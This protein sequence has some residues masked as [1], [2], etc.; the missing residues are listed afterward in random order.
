MEKI[1]GTDTDILGAASSDGAL[2]PTKDEGPQPKTPGWKNRRPASRFIRVI[3][4][5]VCRN[6]EPEGPK[7]A[8]KPDMPDRMPNLVEHAIELWRL[9]Q[10]LGRLAAS[11]DEPQ[12]D[13]VM[14]SIQRLKRYLEK[15]DI[16]I[17]DHTNQKFNQGRNLDVL[18]VEQSQDVTEPFIKETKEPTILCK[19]QLV[20]RGKVIVTEGISEHE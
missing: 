16:E 1:M 2:K 17:V 5:L 19:N 10:R 12:R 7:A 14:N 11:L 20:H 8:P 13:L 4:R 18:L 9:E 15:N 3:K 6:R